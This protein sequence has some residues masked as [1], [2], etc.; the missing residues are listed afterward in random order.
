MLENLK[1]FCISTSNYTYNQL[2]KWNLLNGN[3]FL[4]MEEVTKRYENTAI[5]APTNGA[6][7]LERILKVADPR[8]MAERYDNFYI[9]NTQI[10]SLLDHYKTTVLHPSINGKMYRN[11]FSFSTI[12]EINEYVVLPEDNDWLQ[13]LPLESKDYTAWKHVQPLTLWWNDSYE[14]TF[15]II[16]VGNLRFYIYAPNFSMWI[17]DTPALVLKAV[18]YF[19]S[20]PDGNIDVYIKDVIKK[21][22]EMLMKLWFFK[23][24]RDAVDIVLEKKTLQDILS[25]YK[26]RM[27]TYSY[28]G[29]NLEE[30][31][32]EL[33]VFFNGIKNGIIK[34]IQAFGLSI[35]FSSDVNDLETKYNLS[36]F[37]QYKAM[38]LLRDIPYID[39]VIDVYSLNPDLPMTKELKLKLKLLISKWK[40]DIP[41]SFIK[42]ELNRE[43]IKRYLNKWQEFTAKQ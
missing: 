8:W 43:Y 9:Y 29:P 5:L 28:I 3:V 14:Q 31:L 15:D 34:P 7:F 25:L 11:L 4:K 12:K 33:I 38:L 41:L 22:P 23:L 36:H 10:P 21:I 2:S 16:S 35:K 39:Y 24:Q 17:L 1:K 20:F 40:N 27:S 26:T 18:Q 37:H 13:F 6:L 19:R 30:A 42:S 32:E